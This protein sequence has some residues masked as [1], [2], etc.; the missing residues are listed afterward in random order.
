MN[1]P[2]ELFEEGLARAQKKKEEELRNLERRKAS[3]PFALS[4]REEDRLAALRGFHDDEDKE[5]E[6]MAVAKIPGKPRSCV[7]PPKHGGKVAYSS[8]GAALAALLRRVA[9]TAGLRVYHCGACTAW[10]LT[11]QSRGRRGAEK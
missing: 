5:V 6:P 3:R 9:Q 7:N 4:P 11:K 2:H 8:E 10:H 1:V